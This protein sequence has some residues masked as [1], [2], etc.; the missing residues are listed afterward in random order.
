VA[1]PPAASP[2][3]PVAAVVPLAWADRVAAA[4]AAADPDSEVV[5]E[6]RPGQVGATVDGDRLATP[7]TPGTFPDYRSIVATDP[8]RGAIDADGLQDLLPVEAQ[9]VGLVARDGS[10]HV[11]VGDDAGADVL[12][13][14]EFLHEALAV[15]GA[16]PTLVLDGPHRPLAIRGD[17]AG[18]SVLMPVAPLV[19]GDG[20]SDGPDAT[21]SN[22][23]G[24]G[25][26]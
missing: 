12:V 15:A 11:A 1:G 23:E 10:V 13:D 3:E 25:P 8:G 9:T 18:F 4:C 20:A 7:V 24:A 14:P 2:D 5:V 17:G 26:A 16:R 21:T 19:R 6:L 22:G